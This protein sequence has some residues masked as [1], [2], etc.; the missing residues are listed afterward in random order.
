MYI[1][2]VGALAMVLL[3]AAGC[4]RDLSGGGVSSGER[5]TASASGG[6][7]STERATPREN[8]VRP[9]RGAKSTAVR[10]HDRDDRELFYLLVLGLQQ[11]RR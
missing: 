8:T 4:V 7:V 9:E 6:A 3:F 1:P 11:T 2:A 5:A 10:P